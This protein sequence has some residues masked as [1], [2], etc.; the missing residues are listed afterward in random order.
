M[1]V[2]LMTDEA[3]D[4]PTFKDPP[5]VEVVCGVLFEPLEDFAAPH[6]GLYWQSLQPAYPYFRELGALPPVI[7]PAEMPAQILPAQIQFS[8]KPL[9]RTWFMNEDQSLII[10]VQRDRFLT[11]WKKV[12]VGKDYPRYGK[13]FGHFR[14]NFE[15][16]QSFVKESELG[17]IQALQYELTYVN[18]IPQG[19][20]W[21]SMATL[22]G[23][24]RDFGWQNGDRFLPEPETISWNSTFRLPGGE[25]RL[26]V[27]AA[28]AVRIEDSQPVIQLTFTAR[29]IPGDKRI[30]NM[31][32]WFDMARKW[33]VKG[34]VDLTSTQAQDET[35]GLEK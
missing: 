28:N 23:V 17:D 20:G 15:K 10:Q 3:T 27:A 22:G 13:V 33:I 4:L 32:N 18:H 5:V 19:T 14:E 9:L 29:G 31:Q 21:T 1:K 6:L 7:E 8:D 16:F 24:F 26:H 30:E 35:W 12:K 11:N 2:K 25:G 34:F